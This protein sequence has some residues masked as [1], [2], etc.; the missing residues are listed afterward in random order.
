MLTHPLCPLLMGPPGVDIRTAAGLLTEFLSRDFQSPAQLAAY[1]GLAP[2]TRRSARSIRGTTPSRPATGSS[3]ALLLSPF[4]AR[5]NSVSRDSYDRK[6]SQRKRH[7]QALIA[8]V[9]RHCT[10]SFAMLR[11]APSYHPVAP[12][13]QLDT[14]MRTLPR[15]TAPEPQSVFA[16]RLHI[17]HHRVLDDRGTNYADAC[18]RSMPSQQR[19]ARHV[20]LCREQHGSALETGIVRVKRR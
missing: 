20:N 1:A 8:L 12:K 13:N 9:R 14:H 4:A 10:V 19:H 5:R 18:R 2:V 6:V 3:S 15:R 7:S 16:V 11:D 17:P